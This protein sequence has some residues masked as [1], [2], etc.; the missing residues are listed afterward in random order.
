MPFDN[1]IISD[2]K[3]ILPTVQPKKIYPNV[4][5]LP[6]RQ[7]PLNNIPIKQDIVL[8]Q[9]PKESIKEQP[10][11]LHVVQQQEQIIPIEI[12]FDPKTKIEEKTTIEKPIILIP[13]KP[14][15]KHEEI[16]YVPQLTQIPEIPQKLEQNQQIVQ[17]QI[18]QQID[19]QYPI[20]SQPKDETNYIPWIVGIG[21]LGLLL[22]YNLNSNKKKTNDDNIRYNI[23][24]VS[25]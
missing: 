14:E 6:A 17:D 22:Y 11:E 15:P 20:N 12:P 24:N 16:Q 3:T 25:I 21:G 18:Q 19:L 9:I 2:N 4:P 13:T 10:K 1:K 23:N 7:E 8:T 5:P